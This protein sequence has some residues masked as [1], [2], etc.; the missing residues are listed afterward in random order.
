MAEANI[1]IK[2]YCSFN[3]RQQMVV[4][5]N[6]WRVNG[7]KFVNEMRARYLNATFACYATNSTHALMIYA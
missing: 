2:D 4:L 1:W 6:Q 7:A 5:Q 3:F